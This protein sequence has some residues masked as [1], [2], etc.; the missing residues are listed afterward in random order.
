MT[1][2]CTSLAAVLCLL[3]IGGAGAAPRA[4][5]QCPP[6]GLPLTHAP[7]AGLDAGT[8]VLGQFEGG[9]ALLDAQGRNQVKATSQTVPA[10]L[11][12]TQALQ[13]P[14]GASVSI[15]RTGAFLPSTGTIEMWVRPPS[16]HVG[17]VHLF[18]LRGA[19]SLDGDGFNE[20]FVGE[21]TDA[22]ALAL[23][24]LYF[25]H[26]A[27]PDLA[28]PAR[29]LS[30][31]PRGV[32]SG[33]IDGDG[34]PDL[35]VCMNQAS[36]LP[37]PATPVPGE[38]HIFHGPFAPDVLYTPDAVL[39][40]DVPQGLVLADFDQDGDL[41]LMV[42][43]FNPALPAVFGLANDG[44]GSFS[45]MNL[46]YAEI[47]A[48]AEGLAAA[49][50]NADG[51]LDLLYGSFGVPSSRVLL[52]AIGPSGYTFQDVAL[53]SSERSNETLGVSFGDLD[54]DG[55][56]DAVLAQPLHDNGGGPPGRIAVHFNDG[57]GQYASVPDLVVLA[58]RA[59]TLNASCDLDQ[60]GWLDIA[61]ANWRQGAV[62]TPA[63][64][65]FFG[66]FPQPAPGPGP[67]T[68]TPPSR[69]FAV[70]DA[71][72]LA[73]GDLDGD[74]LDDLF[75][76]SSTASQSPAFFLD[77]AGFSKAG[78]AGGLQAPSLL[79]PT[80]PT[81]GNPA[82]EGVGAAA[83]IVGGTTAYGTVH[84][85]SGSF[86]LFVDG[87]S[88]HFTLV[89]SAGV[90]REVVAPLPG[91]GEPDAQNGFQHVQA[92]W[93]AA[94]GLLQL[95]VGHPWG[96][97]NVT[98]SIGTPFVAG[99]VSPVFR[100][101]S[102][103]GNQFRAEGWSLDD[104]RISS[105]RRSRIDADGDGVPDEWDNCEQTPNTVQADEDGDGI[106]NACAVCQADVG[107]GGPGSATLSVCGQPLASCQSA[108]IYLSGAPPFMPLILSVGLGLNPLPFAGGQLVTFPTALEL[109]AFTSAQ[110]AI[111]IK[112]PG[113]L[114]VP[115]LYLQARVRDWSQPFDVAISNAVLVEFLP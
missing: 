29:I 3:A 16:R 67:V 43:C 25:N 57:T 95:R 107:F 115:P 10:G 20:L 102:D 19:G 86:D 31:T 61:V 23:S 32:A 51:V 41:D 88:L 13:I 87:D 104:V 44:D 80:Q 18:S 81:L 109:F 77:A 37:S 45:L 46:P 103:A 72:S 17:R 30:I 85:R 15:Y 38:I 64:T 5:A 111:K 76:R 2:P 6:P 60:D 106:G 108:S 42:A 9:T 28:H 65:V 54:G 98:S 58:P 82:G 62:S 47:V 78:V 114:A 35:V 1:A 90:L 39:E 71:V 79:L 70:P 33:D 99:A 94:E 91:P 63:S 14:V 40:L 56:P 112:V 55:W 96:A 49:D 24:R 110:G 93:S 36:T 11:F 105:V 50:V 34:A 101:G 21:A 92:E 68:L 53:T 27:G 84:D 4:A 100:L 113:G 75:F 26:G 8:V 22:P 83:P 7:I 12:G 69:A 52:G 66:P 73:L 89:D 97:D 48:G 59:F 74:G